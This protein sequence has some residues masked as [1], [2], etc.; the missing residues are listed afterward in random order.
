M[1][2]QTKTFRAFLEGFGVNTPDDIT[3]GR[4][5]VY[6]Q[7]K[8]WDV[9]D[10]CI[11]FLEFPPEIRKMIYREALAPQAFIPQGIRVCLGAG[12][13]FDYPS[14]SQPNLQHP[15]PIVIAERPNIALLQTCQKVYFEAL[16]LIWGPET[17]AHFIDPEQFMMV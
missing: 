6:Q 11:K 1:T 10:K 4:K 2:Y 3:C 13:I 17:R 5:G 8:W 7:Q 12:C 16:D 14:S 9:N 15:N